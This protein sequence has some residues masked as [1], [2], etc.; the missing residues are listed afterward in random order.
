MRCHFD[1]AFDVILKYGIRENLSKEAIFFSY[2]DVPKFIF[3]GDISKEAHDFA[4]DLIENDIFSLPSER[5]YYQ[6]DL[7][8]RDVCIFICQIEMQFS[9]FGVVIGGEKNPRHTGWIKARL[10]ENHKAD[11]WADSLADEGALRAIFHAMLQL[12]SMLMFKGLKKSE[13]TI[14]ARLN[15]KREQRGERKLPSYT[16]IDTRHYYEKT[17]H[18]GGTHASPRPHFR[19]GHVRVLPAGNKT[20]V[21]PCF[22]M[23]ETAQMPTYQV[24]Q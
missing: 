21:R 15:R 24:R 9:I 4:W 2:L 22:V 6:F 1:R 16:V 20:I 8:D 12:T 18:Q 23:A 14:P 11:L 3:N 19:R 13:I 10:K 17:G 7:D 5:V